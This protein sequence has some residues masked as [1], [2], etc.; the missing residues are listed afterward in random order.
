MALDRI[1]TLEEVAK[2]FHFELRWLREFIKARKLP[3]LGTRNQMRFNSCALA[4][5]EEALRCPCDERTGSRSGATQAARR[6]ISG[7]DYLMDDGNAFAALQR[8]QPSRDRKR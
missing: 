5:L 6:S 2:R 3:Y 7:Y 1:Y 8:R 4:A